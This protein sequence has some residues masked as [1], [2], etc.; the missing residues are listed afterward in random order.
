VSPSTGLAQI[1]AFI[2]DEHSLTLGCADAAHPVTPLPANFPAAAYYPQTGIAS[3][4][5]SAGRPMRPSLFITDITNDPNCRAG[6]EQNSGTAYD[7]VAVFGA[8]K[9]ADASATPGADPTPLNYWNLGPGAD[10]VPAAAT[11]ACPCTPDSCV[12]TG[13]AGRGYGTEVRYEVGFI[14]GHSYRLQIIVHDGDQK[15]GG[16]AGEAC[17]IFCAGGAPCVP[18]GCAEGCGPTPDGCGG[19]IDCGP[20]CVP[21]TCEEVCAS[22]TGPTCHA[23]NDPITGCVWACP[24]GDGCGNSIPCWCQLD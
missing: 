20:C 2:N 6:D 16:D 17:A 9:S 7:P 1:Q 23:A 24:Q 11:A 8:W 12:T 10:A 3:C 4:V 19:I 21:L 15:Q 18:T 5:D 13:D 14:A 22:A